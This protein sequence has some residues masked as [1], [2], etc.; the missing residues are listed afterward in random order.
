MSEHLH[1]DPDSLNSFLE[2]VLP[3]HERLQ[4]MAHLSECSRCRDIVFMARGAVPAPV[5]SSAAPAWR[6]WFAPVPVFVAAAAVFVVALALSWYLRRTSVQPE[7]VARV[8]TPS[9]VPGVSSTPEI[10]P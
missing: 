3:E 6:R 4:C 8:A 9:P 1:P 10:K 5:A 7:I 2:G